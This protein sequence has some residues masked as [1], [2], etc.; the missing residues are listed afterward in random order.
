M[1]KIIVTLL[2][3][4]VGLATVAS[5][6]SWMSTQTDI[7]KNDANSSIERLINE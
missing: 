4:L 7:L 2:L 3:I 5:L 6:S 1:D